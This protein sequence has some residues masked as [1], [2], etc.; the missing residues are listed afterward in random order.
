[1]YFYED[2]P[3]KKKQT[4]SLK[5]KKRINMRLNRIYILLNND[6]KNSANVRDAHAYLFDSPDR[7][8]FKNQT[9]I[10]S[11]SFLF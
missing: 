9:S 11:E 2:N 4:P 8:H 7:G 6:R 5:K 3:P 10:K 1:M